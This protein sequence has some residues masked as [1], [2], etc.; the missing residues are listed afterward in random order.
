MKKLKCGNTAAEYCHRAPFFADLLDHCYN[1]P[2]EE[3]PDYD[4]IR[5]K[6]KKI[7]LEQNMSPLSCFNWK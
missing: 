1:I 3:A 7:L 2:F 4:K 5:F 6:L